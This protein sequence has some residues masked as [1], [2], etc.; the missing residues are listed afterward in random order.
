MAIL[1][2]LQQILSSRLFTE[3]AT[4]GRA[5]PQVTTIPVHSLL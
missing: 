3:V 1:T 4:A 5:S 2:A